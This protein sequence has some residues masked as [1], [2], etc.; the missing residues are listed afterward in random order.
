[1]AEKKGLDYKQLFL[2]L[3]VIPFGFIAVLRGSG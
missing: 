2:Y 1:M 3:I